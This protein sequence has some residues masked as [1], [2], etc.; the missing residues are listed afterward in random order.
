VFG[1][2]VA[3]VDAGDF[4]GGLELARQAEQITADISGS[5][6][7]NWS[8]VM[9]GLLAEAGDL[10]AAEATCAA[11]LARCREAGDMWSLSGLLNVGAELDLR[12]DRTQ[13]AA[14]HLQEALQITARTGGGWELV[15]ILYTCAWLCAA[16]GRHADALTAR[17][18]LTA[19]AQRAGRVLPE[20]EADHPLQQ[21]LRS[22]ER[23]LGPARTRAAE[24]RGAAMSPATAAEYALMRGSVSD[25]STVKPPDRPASA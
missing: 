4:R 13:D 15:N 24:E 18:A 3:A 19:S 21:A 7:R 25:L 1:L 14:A 22:A 8:A 5:A 12:S 6:A 17:A 10:A 2:I 20:L 9:T 16:A 23:A 11:G